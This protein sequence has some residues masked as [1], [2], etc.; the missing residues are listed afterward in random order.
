MDIGETPYAGGHSI[1]YELNPDM[2]ARMHHS[3]SE[4]ESGDEQPIV[5]PSGLA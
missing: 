4:S 5:E 3:R 1:R 2:P